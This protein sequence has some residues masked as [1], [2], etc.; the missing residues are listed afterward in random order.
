MRLSLPFAFKMTGRARLPDGEEI[1]VSLNPVVQQFKRIKAQISAGWNIEHKPDGSHG[2]IT[3]TSVT[4]A[5]DILFSG[6]SSSGLTVGVDTVDGYDD[7][8]AF[9]SGSNAI[10]HGRSAYIGVYGNEAG[11]PGNVLFGIGNAT[12]AELV[13]KRSDGTEAAAIDGATGGMTLGAPT[14]GENGH[15]T[16]N[17]AGDIYKNN[18]AYTNPD[19]VFEHAYTGR[20]ARFADRDGA[21]RYRGLLSLSALEAHVREHHRFPQIPDQPM[22]T[23]ARSDVALE[24]IEQLALY[25]FDHE[26]RLVALE[27]NARGTATHMRST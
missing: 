21:A 27:A 23:F 18:S 19:Y 5:G 25:L 6:A 3:V 26:R 4:T 9:L 11:T 12:G 1:D 7:S 13:V 17:A 15:G 20:I 22:G 16:L 2:A 10:A 14:G 8:A 24:L